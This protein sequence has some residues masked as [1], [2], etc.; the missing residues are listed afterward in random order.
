MTPAIVPIVL[1]AVNRDLAEMVDSRA[2]LQEEFEESSVNRHKGPLIK[3]S[4]A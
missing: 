2:M 4:V 1:G 3:L